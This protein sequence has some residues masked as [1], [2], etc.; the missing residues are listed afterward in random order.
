VDPGEIT[1]TG[2]FVGTLD[3]IA[4]E[5]IEGRSVDGR[6]DQY[7]LACAAFE[8]LSGSLPFKRDQAVAVPPT[9]DDFISSA[10]L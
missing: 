1:A 10:A 7:A 8:M 5:Q 6:T 4:P 2:Q 9:V 3:Y